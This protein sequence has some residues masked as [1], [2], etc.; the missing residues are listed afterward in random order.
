MQIGSMTNRQ[1]NSYHS[2]FHRV[3]AGRVLASTKR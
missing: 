3:L 1:K 2:G